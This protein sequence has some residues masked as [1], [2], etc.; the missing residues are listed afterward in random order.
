M[1][2]A[3]CQGSA[4]HLWRNY[5]K[6]RPNATTLFPR[7]FP[8]NICCF[9]QKYRNAGQVHQ[10]KN[11]GFVHQEGPPFLALLKFAFQT[12]NFKSHECENQILSITTPLGEFKKFGAD[13]PVCLSGKFL[14]ISAQHLAFLMA[15][16]KLWSR[17]IFFSGWVCR[18]FESPSR[19]LDA[20]TGI[21]S[22]R[23][24]YPSNLKNTH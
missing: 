20:T 1:S 12:E 11:Q 5:Q 4:N 7:N 22:G 2:P 13:S 16:A 6:A 24:V 23:R 3:W 17:F 21:F 19:R 10:K 14:T 9:R 8:C 18:E 15:L